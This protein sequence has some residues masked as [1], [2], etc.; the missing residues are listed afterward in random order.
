MVLYL[1]KELDDWV[2]SWRMTNCPQEKM[3]T[4]LKNAVVYWAQ[5]KGFVCPHRFKEQMKQNEKGIYEM[6]NECVI[7][8][9]QG[10]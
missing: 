4:I 7:C 1:H 9:I 3:S 6:V 5:S 8:R 2:R 10:N